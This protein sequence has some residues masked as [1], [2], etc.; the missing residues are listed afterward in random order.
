[1]RS[2]L[3]S[4]MRSVTRLQGRKGTTYTRGAAHS[5]VVVVNAEATSSSYGCGEKMPTEFLHANSVFMLVKKVCE[6]DGGAAMRVA[7]CWKSVD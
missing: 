2:W 7:L 1:M 4:L 3:H 5:A 6:V